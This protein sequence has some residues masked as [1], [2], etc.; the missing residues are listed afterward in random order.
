MWAPKPKGGSGITQA[1]LAWPDP[2]TPVKTA[3]ADFDQGFRSGRSAEA[4]SPNPDAIARCAWD[5]SEMTKR[6]K[7]SDLGRLVGSLRAVKQNAAFDAVCM[8]ASLASPLL[9][10]PFEPAAGQAAR[11]MPS[12]SPGPGELGTVEPGEDGLGEQREQD[13]VMAGE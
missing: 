10:G 6:R 12:L 9:D 7:R 1:P 4:V 5:S 13:L 2:R 3:S 11:G 8:A